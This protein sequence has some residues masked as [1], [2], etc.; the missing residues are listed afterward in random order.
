MK[1]FYHSVDLDGKC[2]AAIIKD[3]YQ[4]C[5]LFPINYGQPFPIKKI[6]QREEVYIVDFTLQPFEQMIELEK[7]ANLIWIDHHS[8]SIEESISRNFQHIKGIRDSRLAACEL[9]WNYIHKSPIP[10]CINLLGRYDVWDLT[11]RDVLPFQYG[12]RTINSEPT[13]DIWKQV[14]NSSDEFIYGMISKGRVVLDYLKIDDEEYLHSF[15]SEI[16]FEDYKCLCVNKGKTSSQ[17][18]ESKWN[19]DTYDI[20][21]TFCRLPSKLWTISMYTTKKHINVGRIAKKYRGGGHTQAAGFQCEDLP[22][23]V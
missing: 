16:I 22:F 7:Y 21:M 3:M 17:L 9:V 15:C 14:F 20:M 1:C 11:N 5:E 8:S 23:D 10:P 13:S 2:S 12:M 6:K 19:E 18:F 4:Q